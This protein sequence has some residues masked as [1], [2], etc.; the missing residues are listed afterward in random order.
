M[1]EEIEIINHSNTENKKEE[2]KSN[3]IKIT[4]K[5]IYEYLTNRKIYNIEQIEKLN[6]NEL[7]TIKGIGITRINKFLQEIKSY[8]IELKCNNKFKDE[9]IKINEIDVRRGFIQYCKKIEKKYLYD[10]KDMDFIKLVEKNKIRIQDAQTILNEYCILETNSQSQYEYSENNNNLEK[11]IEKNAKS[12]RTYE[13]LLQETKEK[14]ISKLEDFNTW[15][16]KNIFKYEITPMNAKDLEKIL[17][18]VNYKYKNKLKVIFQDDGEIEQIV[19]KNDYKLICEKIHKMGIRKI[20]E[21]KELNLL[22]ICENRFMNRLQEFVEDV[23]VL[24]EDETHLIEIIKNL[25]IEIYNYCQTKNWIKN[26]EIDFIDIFNNFETEQFDKLIEQLDYKYS[27]NNL[28]LFLYKELK[29]IKKENTEME[30]LYKKVNNNY[31][32]EQIG[33]EIGI[34]RERIRQKIDKIENKMQKYIHI[35]YNVFKNQINQ[36]KYMDNNFLLDIYKVEDAKVVKHILKN[37]KINNLKYIQELD[38][39]IFEDSKDILK[40]YDK[41]IDSLGDIFNYYDEIDNIEDML[42]KEEIGYL[43]IEYFEKYIVEQKG[44]HLINDNIYCKNNSNKFLFSYII[45]NF[46]KDGIKTD[47]EGIEKIKEKITEVLGDKYEYSKLPHAIKN[48]LLR[49]EALILCDNNKYIHF[50]SVIIDRHLI[51][52]IKRE[53]MRLLKEKENVTANTLYDIFKDS[54]LEKTSINNP[55]YLYGVLKYYYKDEFEF[56]RLNISKISNSEASTKTERISEY[57]LNRGEAVLKSEI[58]DKFD[59]TETACNNM[60]SISENLILWDNFKKIQNINLIKFPKELD[61]LTIK[62]INDKMKKGY[63]SAYSLYKDMELDFIENKINDVDSL[64]NFLKIKYESI[65]NFKGAFILDKSIDLNKFD[66]NYVIKDYFKDYDRIY[67]RDIVG[68]TEKMNFRKSVSH[69]IISKLQKELF[70]IDIDEY[71][72]PDYFYLSDEQINQIKEF[73]DR[74]IE[75]KRYIILKNIETKMSN[76]PMIGNYSWNQ[77]LMN[78]IIERK[79]SKYYRQIDREAVDW[80]Y[81]IPI[82]VR[83]NDEIRNMN[84]FILFIIKEKIGKKFIKISM[85]KEVLVQNGITKQEIPKEFLEDERIIVENDMIQIL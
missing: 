43:P 11:I 55:Q 53:L 54:L 80:R 51:N 27:G 2:N 48:T 30:L 73:L 24:E 12:K 19:L 64:L 1:E 56:N 47:D 14:N 83:K 77:F 52:Q 74:E 18:L 28:T 17:K 25:D 23:F 45:K 33:N 78:S 34:T 26:E 70:K 42:E 61:E 36:E 62:T 37:Y 8:G 21:L 69:N 22:E 68:F 49:D 71:I 29:K 31:T 38:I 41:I 67:R 6:K 76:L 75:G 81:Y 46:F 57:I 7:L 9:N 72:Y 15:D 35:I 79:L 3:N 20:G 84:D 44:Y 40:I 16:Y 60:I 63:V 85:L 66:L 10:L 59:L 82:I 58:E 50:D 65:Y 13:I 32:L 39:F 4:D 5:I